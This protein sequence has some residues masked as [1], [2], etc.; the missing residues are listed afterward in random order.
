MQPID[1]RRTIFFT[2]LYAAAFVLN[3]CWESLHGL[4]YDAHQAIPASAY[5]PMMVRMAL[6]DALAVVGIY[7]FA[8]LLSRRLVWV[9]SLRSFTLFSLSALVPAWGVEYIAVN[10][11]HAWSYSPG[12]PVVLSVGLSPLLQMPATG[13]AAVTVAWCVAAPGKPCE[14]ANPNDTR[15]E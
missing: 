15:T 7:L 14:P 1:G 9:P 6:V 11:L 12:M 13:I 2:S 4:L 10:I 5:V 8:S 3:F